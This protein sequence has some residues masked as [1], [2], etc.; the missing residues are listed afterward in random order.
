MSQNSSV[1]NL[2]YNTCMVSLP[3]RASSSCPVEEDNHSGFW[4]YIA[5][6]PLASIL[7]PLCTSGTV[8]VLR[9]DTVFNMPALI[10]TPTHKA[11]APLHT[12]TEAVPAP[13]WLPT[14]IAKLRNSH[15]NNSGIPIF[16]IIIVRKSAQSGKNIRQRSK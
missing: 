3:I 2:L 16:A 6:H 5:F 8:G 7:K 1:L 15:I 9:N 12:G 10:G 11:C 13:I 14:D 4:S